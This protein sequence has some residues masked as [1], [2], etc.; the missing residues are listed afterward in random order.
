MVRLRHTKVTHF[1]SLEKALRHKDQNVRW[2]LENT[3]TQ[4]STRPLGVGKHSDTEIKTSVGSWKTLRDC[5]ESEVAFYLGTPISIITP[6]YCSCRSR[7]LIHALNL[8]VLI[9]NRNP[10]I[11]L[12]D[13]N[14]KSV[15]FMTTSTEVLPLNIISEGS[16]RSLSVVV[17]LPAGIGKSRA[18]NAP[19]IAE[20]RKMHFVLSVARRCRKLEDY[21]ICTAPECEDYATCTTPESEDNA[22]FNARKT[23]WVRPAMPGI[24]GYVIFKLYYTV[25]YSIS[26]WKGPQYSYMYRNVPC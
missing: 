5:I 3:P 17:I 2:E 20:N 16:C 1:W 11:T 8:H 6:R 23:I 22:K 12:E 18:P 24:V 25:P 19:N 9:N 21:A 14:Y 7:T 26:T 4:I 13:Y 10:I 15:R